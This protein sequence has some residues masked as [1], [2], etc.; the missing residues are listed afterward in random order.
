MIVLNGLHISVFFVMLYFKQYIEVG[1]FIKLVVI[2]GYFLKLI[3][4]GSMLLSKISC[5][6]Q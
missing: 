6:W 2:V 3:V 4:I 1:Y 5:D